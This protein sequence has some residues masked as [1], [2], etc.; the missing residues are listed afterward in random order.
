MSTSSDSSDQEQSDI[1]DSENELFSDENG[2][3]EEVS[4]SVFLSV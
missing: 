3:F 4:L 1:Y 2:E